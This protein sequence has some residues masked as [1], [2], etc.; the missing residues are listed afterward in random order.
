MENLFAFEYM[1]EKL[2]P[3]ALDYRTRNGGFLFTDFEWMSNHERSHRLAT[4]Q[5][6]KGV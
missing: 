4:E 2:K 3:W 1:W 5:K 6:A